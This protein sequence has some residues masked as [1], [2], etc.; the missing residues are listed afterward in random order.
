MAI[1]KKLKAD[2]DLQAE[3]KR[4]RCLGCAFPDRINRVLGRR[5]VI[6]PEWAFWACLGM[7]NMPKLKPLIRQ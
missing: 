7:P 4:D 2:K 1:R 3:L 5:K 6:P